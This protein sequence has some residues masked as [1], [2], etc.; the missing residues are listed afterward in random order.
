MYHGS[1]S[2]FYTVAQ[3]IW[4]KKQQGTKIIS[5]EIVTLSIELQEKKKISSKADS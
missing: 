4:C 5:T 3:N 2:S 1:S